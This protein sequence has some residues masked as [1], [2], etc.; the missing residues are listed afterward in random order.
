MAQTIWNLVEI[1][2]KKGEFIVNLA[3]SPTMGQ[4]LRK[5][6]HLFFKKLLTNRP[7]F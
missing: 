1:V 6:L 4:L 3:K 2:A 7:N 5:L